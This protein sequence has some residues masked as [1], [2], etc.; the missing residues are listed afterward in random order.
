M[1]M[2]E[3]GRQYNSSMKVFFDALDDLSSHFKENAPGGIGSNAELN[4]R[5]MNE[6]ADKEKRRI[7]L[8]KS[9]LIFLTKHFRYS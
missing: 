5:L 6:S 3:Q 8:G 1:A 4:S 7:T 9:E 2:I